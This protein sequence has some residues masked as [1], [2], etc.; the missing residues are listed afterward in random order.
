M[1]GR[2]GGKGARDDGEIGG[3]MY[4]AWTYW[5][6]LGVLLLLR[7]NWWGCIRWDEGT[8]MRRGVPV[9]GESVGG[10]FWARGAGG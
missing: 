10:W 5:G 6:H 9:M 1:R 2:V 8:G 4:D 7:G 3:V